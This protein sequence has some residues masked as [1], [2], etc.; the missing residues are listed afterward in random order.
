[1][2]VHLPIQWS[3]AR[4][5]NDHKL[6]ASLPLTTGYGKGSAC[7]GRC[8]VRR[9]VSCGESRRGEL[10]RRKF[11]WHRHI[12]QRYAKFAIRSQARESLETDGVR[13]VAHG[14][15]VENGLLF[16]CSICKR[17]MFYLS[18]YWQNAFPLAY[19]EKLFAFSY[20]ETFAEDGWSVY[21]PVAELRRMVGPLTF[22]KSV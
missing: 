8:S 14:K 17:K 19:N 10:E 20:T 1:M 4:H 22:S 12:L 13:K 16:V 21:E 15:K 3:I 2:H 11:L 6:P 18:V 9:C 7:C 5:F